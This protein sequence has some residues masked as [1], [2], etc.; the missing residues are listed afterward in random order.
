MKER[1]GVDMH[2]LLSSC[3][4][5]ADKGERRV[6]AR[7]AEAW[8]D[9]AGPEV[10]RHTLGVSLNQAELLVLVDSPV[11][12]N[13][14]SLLAPRY[15]NALNA[16]LGRDLVGSVRFTVSRRVRQEASRR[17]AEREEDLALAKKLYEEAGSPQ[18]EFTFADTPDYIKDFAPDFVEGLRDRIGANVKD[19]KIVGYPI[20]AEELLKGCDV[21]KATWGFDNGWIDLDDWVFPYFKTRESKNSFG[22]S[23]PDL[24]PLLD[25]QRRE[26]DEEKRRDIGYQIQRYLMG[27]KPDGS[28][29]LEL[30]PTT[31]AYAR[32]DYATLIIAYVSWPYL[33]NRMTF[34]WFGN[35][36]WIANY[37]LNREDKSWKGRA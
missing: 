23:D 21:M 9:V 25:A 12:A 31:A 24:D 29:P 28:G 35:N 18:L 16:Y 6:R 4:S 37:W 1:R 36:H 10:G 15:A 30:K 32:L 17:K 7:A 22:V 19:E 33:M 13:E 2:A 26:F 3:V 27:M 5:R 34:P 8:A 11:W 20:I 14:L